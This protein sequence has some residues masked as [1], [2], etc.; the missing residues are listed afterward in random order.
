M[1]MPNL[2]TAQILD[3]ISLHSLATH[4]WHAEHG[5]ALAALSLKLMRSEQMGASPD[6]ARLYAEQ[7]LALLPSLDALKSKA[8]TFGPVEIAE[9]ELT[10][11]RGAF[12]DAD[13][14]AL[15]AIHAYKAERDYGAYRPMADERIADRRGRAIGYIRRRSEARAKVHA[16]Q[17]R[18][19][20]ARVEAA[21]DRIERHWAP[22]KTDAAHPF[23]NLGAA[24]AAE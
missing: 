17:A 5:P 1:G 11:A 22:R 16:A 7:R 9:A 6:S 24:M 4:A 8:L 18:L 3:R 14:V 10:I 15:Q 23:V 20:A 12:V 19:E 13:D 21:L 2:T